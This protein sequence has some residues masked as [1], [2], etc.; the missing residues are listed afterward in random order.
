MT[1]PERVAAGIRRKQS[2]CIERSSRTGANSVEWQRSALSMMSSARYRV[3]GQSEGSKQPRVSVIIPTYNY[4]SY[5]HE[6]LRSVFAQTF[7][8]FEVIV[9]DD[10]STDNT[11]HL[12]ETITDPRLKCFRILNSGIPFA[13]N[14]GLKQSLGAYIAFLDADDRWR[15]KKLE[16]QLAVL[17]SEP[18]VGVVFSDFVRFDE[19]G[20]LPNQFTFFPELRSVPARDSADGRG[21]VALGDA[22][23]ELLRFGQFPTYLQAT[24]IRQ[25]VIGE[26]QFP[27]IL[28]QGEDLYFLMRLFERS[29]VAF[30]PE[31]LTEVRR[32]GSNISMKVD[33]KPAWDL[34]ALV[35]LGQDVAQNH[36]HAVRSR[37]ARVHASIGY[38]SLHSGRVLLAARH[39]L[40]CLAFPGR[41]ANALLH[42]LA[43]PLHALTR[44]KARG[45]T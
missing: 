14:F 8:D 10:G 6:C 15:P 31:V 25:D 26:V 27:L 17:R 28:K 9:V 30:V 39:Y 5:L 35:L 2:Q 19:R 29:G 38:Q 18:S 33:E 42:L 16:C 12:L 40:H 45:G 11:P 7:S 3:G 44:A 23:C 24:L 43:L 21:R 20:Y 36:R 13:R 34:K 22:F 32:H 1:C 4:G 41:R 37:I